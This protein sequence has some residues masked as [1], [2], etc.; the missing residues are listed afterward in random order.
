LERF[1]LLPGLESTLAFRYDRKM[2]RFIGVAVLCL[3]SAGCRPKDD[4]PAWPP[5]SMTFPDDVPDEMTLIDKKGNS[6]PGN[7]KECYARGYR[8]GWKY[9]VFD[10]ERHHLDFS[11]EKP[12]VPLYDDYAIVARGWEDGYSH[13]WEAIR[14]TKP[15]P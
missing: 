1:D 12:E 15:Q 9:C 6:H 13:C 8:G 2:R 11:K 7:G 14:E 10:F 5:F 4:F 3:S